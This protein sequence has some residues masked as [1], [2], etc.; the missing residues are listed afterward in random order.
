MHNYCQIRELYEYFKN[1]ALIYKNLRV[2][3]ISNIIQLWK[4]CM[5]NHL[6]G[7]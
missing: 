3:K 6:K 5:F 2:G 4:L 7:L 1:I